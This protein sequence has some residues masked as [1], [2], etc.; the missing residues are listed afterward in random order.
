[1]IAGVN[2]KESYG[3]KFERIAKRAA[4]SILAR[5]ASRGGHHLNLPVDVNSIKKVIVIRQHN[6]FGD[7]L[8]TVPLLRSM[9][10]KFKLQELA[11]VVSPQNVDALAGCKYATK[12][13]N[14]DK[15]AF[16]RKPSLF[17]NFIKEIRRGYDI[18]LVP[19][20]VSLSL[21]NDIMAFFVRAKKKLGP[22][23]LESKSNRTGSVYDIAVDL[24]WGDNPVHQSYRNM[25]V[26][27]P[28]GIGRE[29]DNGELE[30]K[31][32]SVSDKEANDFVAR[33][34]GKGN[35][36]VALHAGAGKVPNRWNVANFAALSDLL[37]NKLNAEIFLT[38]GP[39][40][41]EVIEELASLMKGPFVRV[42]NKAV[43]FVAAVLKQMDLVITNDTGIMHLAAAVGIPTLS[44]FGPTDPLQWSPLGK[45][46][47]FILGRGGD[48]NTISVDKTFALAKKVLRTR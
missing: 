11:V 13:I 16:Y 26:A 23:S 46:N 38:E 14:Y 4:R 28:L 9:S 20:N 2:N 35:P 43:S 8:C 1:M 3:K 24:S 36:R 42:R 34:T 37:H 47:R 17:F 29:S 32:D 15:L 25:K 39:M 21:T 18:L 44:L 41:H 33:L 30:Y 12:L 48:I 5:L 40:D 31:V 7:V 27:S 6:Q 22:A 10:E 45:R 19:S